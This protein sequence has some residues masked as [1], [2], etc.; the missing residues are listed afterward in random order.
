[1]QDKLSILIGDVFEAASALRRSGE[2][3][4][5]HEGVTLSQWHLMDAIN[6]PSATVARVARRVGQSRQA[7]QKTA[8]ELAAGGL[9]EFKLN[10][11]HKTS[12]L[13]SLTGAGLEV[14]ARLWKRATASHDARFGAMSTRDLEITQATL[15]QMT[16]ITYEAYGRETVGA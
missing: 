9:L 10:P 5:G 4:A 7:A 1:M 6:D 2:E 3:I 11:D 13:I 8:N 14:Q 16:Q 12:P 15:R